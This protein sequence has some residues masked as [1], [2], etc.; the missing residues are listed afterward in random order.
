MGRWGACPVPVCRTN[1]AGG[2]VRG[3]WAETV[4]RWG[5]GWGGAAW[6]RLPAGGPV[7][8]L[9]PAPLGYRAPELAAASLASAG[10]RLLGVACGTGLVARER[11]GPAAAAEHCPVPA[12]AAACAGPG[13]A[14]RAPGKGAVA[15]LEGPP[16]DGTCV[17]A[18]HSD[19]VV[20]PLGEGQVP[21]AAVTELLRVTRAGGFLCLMTRSN[22]SNRGYWAELEAALGQLEGQG[23]WRRVLAQ[24]VECWERA[25]SLEESTQGTG[26]IIYQ[27]CPVP[28]VEEG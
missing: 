1:G 22:P 8:F 13:A 2:R 3:R 17:P 10:A 4:G 16:A 18:E 23:A 26:Y 27:K 20:V 6:R 15:A 24:V 7:P 21:S 14:A 28:P 19:A 25:T 11:G 9:P 5:R 12:A